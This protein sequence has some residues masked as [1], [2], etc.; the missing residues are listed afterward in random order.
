MA[1]SM[2]WSN[3]KMTSIPLKESTEC[4]GSKLTSIWFAEST[5]CCNSKLTSPFV[6]RSYQVVIQSRQQII[7]QAVQSTVGCNPASQLDP[8]QQTIHTIMR[9][10]AHRGKA[11]TRPINRPCL[12]TGEHCGGGGRQRAHGCGQ[13][14]TAARP[15]RLQAG[16]A[17]QKAAIELDVK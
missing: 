13:R 17:T 1:E 12:V 3:F 8:Q 10:E 7:L 9:A 14:S 5:K 4:S 15:A 11:T 2:K 6:S 16:Q